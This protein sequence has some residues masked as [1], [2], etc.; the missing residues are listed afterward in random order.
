[1]QSYKN[2]EQFLLNS[3]SLQSRTKSALFERLKLTYIFNSNAIENNQ[4]SLFETK[5]I[6]E[7]DQVF[8]GKTLQDHIDVVNHMYAVNHLLMLVDQKAKLSIQLIKNLNYIILTNHKNYHEYRGE[9]RNSSQYAIIVGAETQP[10]PPELIEP[11]LIDLLNQY[12][13]KVNESNIIEM[14]AFLH[15]NFERIH[16]FCDGNGRT[17]RLILNL[18]L[19]KNGFPITTFNYMEKE[20]Y[21]HALEKYDQYPSLLNN[22]LDHAITVSQK[23]YCL[24]LNK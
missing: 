10:S 17:G 7:N 22:Y 24:S 16:P 19:M 18:E 6:L 23:Q 11:D 3:K 4:L 9:F 14:N 21:F 8:Q 20:S 13:N 12:H 5:S 2:K 15:A 1:M